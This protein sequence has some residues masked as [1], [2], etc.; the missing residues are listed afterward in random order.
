MKRRFKVL[1]V[2][3]LL[4]TLLVAILPACNNKG[5]GDG[6][7]SLPKD[8]TEQTDGKKG[9]K[10]ES[11]DK[12]T[13]LKLLGPSGS[14]KFIKFEDREK[15]PIWKELSTLIEAANLELEYEIVPREQ[16]DVVIQTRM[17]SADNL[18]DIANISLLADTT[19]LN[20]AKQG[21]ILEVNSLIDEYSNGNIKKMYEETFPL[22]PS[23]TT[24]PDGNMYWFSNL[25]VKT[26]KRTEPGYS[27]FSMLIRKDWLDKF[28]IPEPE[29]A[30]EYLNA[31]KAM[32]EQDA[33][34]NSV[35]DEILMYNPGGF[36]GSIAHWFGLG[37]GLT[38][39]DIENNKVISPWY[40]EGVKE[41]FEYLNKLVNEQI[42]DTGLIGAGSEQQQQAVMENKVSSLSTYSMIQ[43][44]DPLVKQ[45]K[46]EYLPLLPLKAI[47]E[48]TP[49]LMIEP[50]ELVWQKYA[51]TKAC[52]EKKAAIAFFDMIHTIEYATLCQWGIEGETFEEKDGVKMVIGNLSSEEQAEQGKVRGRHLYGDTV[53]P[54]IQIDN[55]ESELAQLPDYKKVNS[56]K[57]LDHKPIFYN[58]N[59]NFLAI[60]TDEQ[61]EEK[62]KILNN[63]TTYSN[64]LAT[65][66]ALG[67][68]SIDDWDKHISELKSLGLDRLI[69]IEQQQLE[70]F[71]EISAK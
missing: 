61:L 4:I 54:R 44:Y 70:R 58:F 8:Q 67:Q 62:T 3:S 36:S 43:I 7:V 45:E 65:K 64:E 68:V 24:A 35:P 56:L 40:Q 23:L 28:D 66:L 12:P 63:L 10:G 14:N 52:K 26:Y 30:E 48:I 39:I 2:L 9:Q 34:G 60:P 38:S 18:P 42:L 19:A 17:A 6:Q 5:D 20:L 29:T 1:I 71:N 31:L 37:S 11:E 47:D 13:K 57:A 25:H 33:N 46:A 21:V 27:P 69:D 53:F 41:Y 32:R 16:Y 59:D 15:Y 49:A 22:A 50:A 55:L 51:I